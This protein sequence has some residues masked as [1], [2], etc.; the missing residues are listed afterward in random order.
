MNLTPPIWLCLGLLCS[1]TTASAAT[2][3]IE[4]TPKV[5]GE[6]LQPSSL[7]YETSA[8]ESFS[9]TRVSYLASDFA[10]QRNDGSWL[11]ISNSVAW[12]DF[13]QNRDSIRLEKLPAG[14]FRAVRFTVGLNANLNHA[15]I[16]TFPAG[17]PLNPNL[18]GLYWGW[19]GG[20]IFLAVEGLWRNSAG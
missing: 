3:Q 15:D 10:L 1:L 7:R 11:E 17:H 18:N 6:N 16:A 14:E 20:Y 19:Q 4:I 8:G 2:L 5:S 13:D 12:L 9:V